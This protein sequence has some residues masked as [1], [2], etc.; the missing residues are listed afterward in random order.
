M[1]N[2]KQGVADSLFKHAGGSV[3]RRL[4]PLVVN[5]SL[6][7]TQMAGLSTLASASQEDKQP[8]SKTQERVRAFALAIMQNLSLLTETRNPLGSLF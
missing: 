7:A 4:L 1:I 2:K 3:N 6:N 8:S 5:I